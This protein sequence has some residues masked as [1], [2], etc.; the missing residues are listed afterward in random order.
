MAGPPCAVPSSA[1]GGPDL[2]RQAAE[3]ELRAWAHAYL[4][5]SEVIRAAD[6]ARISV[7]RIREV[8]GIARTTILRILGSPPGRRG[9][10]PPEP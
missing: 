8:T 4:R 5:R 2:S 1:G 10:N 3:A 6:A 9:Q 7:G